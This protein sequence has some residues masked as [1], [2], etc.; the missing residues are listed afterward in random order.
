VIGE[1]RGWMIHLKDVLM[2]RYVLSKDEVFDLLENLYR[3]GSVR[4]QTNLLALT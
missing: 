3:N 2:E 4:T 1:Y